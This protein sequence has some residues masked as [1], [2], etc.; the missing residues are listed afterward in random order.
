MEDQSTN[1]ETEYISKDMVIDTIEDLIMHPVKPNPDNS[2]LIE[3]YKRIRMKSGIRL[4]DF[5]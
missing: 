1:T 3:L 4:I 5:M 2:Q